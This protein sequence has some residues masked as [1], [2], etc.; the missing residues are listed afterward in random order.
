[1]HDMRFSIISQIASIMHS[2]EGSVVHA[3][4]TG[5]LQAIPQMGGLRLSHGKL[6]RRAV[7]TIGSDD[8][9]VS[10]DH[11][12]GLSCQWY[13]WQ[14]R[15]DGFGSSPRR[16]KTLISNPRC[17]AEVSPCGRILRRE[18]QGEIRSGAPKGGLMSNSG[19]SLAAPMGGMEPLP[20]K[21]VWCLCTG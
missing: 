14:V 21:P 19:L 6:S 17:L 4:G 15:L 8:L 18:P 9:D 11:L 7:T 13:S 20:I 2:R 3:S 10:E 16:G 1:M 12:L 5:Q